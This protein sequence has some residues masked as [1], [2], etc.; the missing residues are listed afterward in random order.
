MYKP[1]KLFNRFF[2]FLWIVAFTLQTGQNVFNSIV[3]VYANSYGYSNAFA[4]ALSIAYLIGAIIGRTAS[5]W[6]TDRKGRRYGIIAGTIFFLSATLLF[7]LPVSTAPFGMFLLRFIHGIGYAIGTTSCLVAAVDVTPKDKTAVGI[8]LNFTGMGAAFALSGILVSTC[9]AGGRSFVFLFLVTAGFLAASVLFGVLSRYENGIIPVKKK[10]KSSL[11]SL[12]APS[13]IPY[14]LVIFVYYT[15]QA[16]I[17]FYL[18]PLAVSK[19]MNDVGL[20]YSLCALS[21]VICSLLFPRLSD[22]FG[23]LAGTLPVCAG[24]LIGFLLFLY[25]HDPVVF[26]ASGLL[27]GASLSG[28]PIF[29]DAALKDTPVYERG[30][31]MA[32]LWLATDL[33]MGLTPIGWGALIDREGFTLPYCSAAFLF[34]AAFVLHAVIE[35]YS[36]RRR[37]TGI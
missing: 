25:T 36:K 35:I 18:V 29:Q 20:V 37:K 33:A 4:G 8:G 26:M 16:L 15:A 31:V 12:I 7:V 10:E 34:I 13:A 2:I 3:A 9:T 23:P 32:T 22:R 6:I 14:A 27:Y 24:G 19:G 5:G 30:S 17:S 1:D 11:S 28:L 21:M